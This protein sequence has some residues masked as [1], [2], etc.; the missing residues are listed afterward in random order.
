MF[1]RPFTWEIEQLIDKDSVGFEIK[2]RKEIATEKQRMTAKQRPQPKRP[3]EIAEPP[4]KKRGDNNRIA[5]EQNRNKPVV[6]YDGFKDK[7]QTMNLA[8]PTQD[9]CA[10]R[11]SCTQNVIAYQCKRCQVAF[12]NRPAPGKH[13][14]SAYQ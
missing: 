1:V 14:C 4:E 9:Q 6:Y 7:F 10:T 2:Q 8:R 5:E 12:K 13:K 11:S 3:L